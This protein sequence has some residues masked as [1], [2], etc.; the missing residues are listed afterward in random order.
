MT[1]GNFYFFSFSLFFLVFFVSKRVF[2]QIS[3]KSL[4][5]FLLISFFFRIFEISF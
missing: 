4:F 3:L 1:E 2:I 5:L